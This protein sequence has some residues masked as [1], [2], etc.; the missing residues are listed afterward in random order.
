MKKHLGVLGVLTLMQTMFCA[1]FVEDTLYNYYVQARSFTKYYS[2]YAVAG[3]GTA[4]ALALPGRA[5]GVGLTFVGGYCLFQLL[6]GYKTIRTLDKKYHVVEQR[7][8]YWNVNS[9]SKGV[10]FFCRWRMTDMFNDGYY[11]SNNGWAETNKNWI[12]SWLI[13]DLYAGRLAVCAEGT[14]YEYPTP[15][16]LLYV[17][18][19]ERA[20]LEADKATLE[21]YTRVFTMVNHPLEYEPDSSYAQLVYPNHNYAS[22]MY[23]ELVTMLERLDILE[24]LIAGIAAEVGSYAWPKSN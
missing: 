1:N 21:W 13:T 18:K 11:W 10:N 3:V 16:D 5:K 6:N 20:M 9:R 22:K 15:A 12:R 23:C 14:L 17:I 8:Q 4:T 7:G 2:S 19:Q 24:E